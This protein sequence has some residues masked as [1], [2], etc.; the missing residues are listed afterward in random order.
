MTTV[1]RSL[2]FHRRN[3]KGLISTIIVAML[4]LPIL[5]LMGY[6]Q[7]IFLFIPVSYMVFILMPT[8]NAYRNYKYFEKN[9]KE[10]EAYNI[11]VNCNLILKL[12]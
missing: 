8:L 10:L 1:E 2:I 3:F 11:N 5:V 12:N 7:K 6:N 9:M 4:L